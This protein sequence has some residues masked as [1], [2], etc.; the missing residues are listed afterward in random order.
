[1]AKYL[2]GHRFD[3]PDDGLEIHDVEHVS[4]EVDARRDLNQFQSVGRQTK[5]G[6]FRHV[7]TFLPDSVASSPLNDTCSTA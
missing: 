3:V 5:N 2:N 7:R 4:I 6:T 1:M